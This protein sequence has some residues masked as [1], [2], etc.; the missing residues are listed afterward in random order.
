[1][2]RTR[3]NGYVRP[4]EELSDDELRTHIIEVSVVIQESTIFQKFM[5]H[6]ED[7][8]AFKDT[9]KKFLQKLEL[10]IKMV[11]F[12]KRDILT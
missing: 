8:K 11:S 3:N 10:E 5:D 12:I 2:V 7:L 9:K 1:M 4:M 6:V